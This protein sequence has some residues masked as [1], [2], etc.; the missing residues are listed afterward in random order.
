MYRG[1][2]FKMEII[3]PVSYSLLDRQHQRLRLE[4]SE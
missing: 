4:W 3:F 2:L 1:G